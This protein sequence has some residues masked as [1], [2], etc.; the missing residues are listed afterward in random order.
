[1]PI[2][3]VSHLHPVAQCML[4]A[5]FLLVLVSQRVRKNL[6]SCIKALRQKVTKMSSD[7]RRRPLQNTS[8]ANRIPK[9]PASTRRRPKSDFGK[10][11]KSVK[12]NLDL[13]I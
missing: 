6:V 7:N 4:I 9:R 3:D 2:L 8:R 11:K 1:M 5:G 12:R 10:K 13:T